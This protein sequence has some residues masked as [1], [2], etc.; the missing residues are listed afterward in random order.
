MLSGVL[1][2][3]EACDE[4]EL[5]LIVSGTHL[6]SNFGSTVNEIEADGRHISAIVP[7]DLTKGDPR[8]LVAA[9]G[10]LAADLATVVQ[11]LSPD[12]ILV[13][14][15][16]Y[17]LLAV[18]MVSVVMRI[19]LAHISGGEIT[20]GAIDEQVR[21]SITKSAHL[22]YVANQE[23]ERRILGMGE[24]PWRV[25]CSGEPGLD[26]VPSSPLYTRTDLCQ[27]L[28]LDPAGRVGLVALHPETGI[29]GA[30]NL[31]VSA[32]KSAISNSSG[33][34]GIQ[35]VLTY[36]NSD[37]G[38]AAIVHAWKELEKVSSRIVLIQSLGRA[39]FLSS[40]SEFDLLLGNSSSG[41]VEAPS[42]SMPAINIG[43]RQRGR[44]RAKNVL[45]V[46]PDAE[47]IVEGIHWALE[48]DRSIP[49]ENP[50]G[51]GRSSPRITEHIKNVL[52]NM[53]KETLLVKRFVDDWNDRR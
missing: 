48:F 43:N 18:Q 36:P 42:F 8:A 12:L 25:V 35:W 17:E 30:T 11:K 44:P 1:D 20:T 19:P 31:L 27:Q 51:D 7:M 41:L 10:S 52:L 46:D 39:R 14:G 13:M 3:L 6:D 47:N 34:L 37:L 26:N 5:A 40:L 45:D 22:H 33:D 38:N 15:D 21:H 4:L 29:P 2:S 9:T 24:E 16:R 32:T 50:Y 23:F 49:I 53:D 28:G